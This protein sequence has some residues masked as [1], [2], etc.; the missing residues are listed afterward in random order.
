MK[1][2]RFFHDK[3]QKHNISTFL[4]IYLKVLDRNIQTRKF[5]FCFKFMT[6]IFRIQFEVTFQ[7][8]DHV[9]FRLQF[10]VGFQIYDR[11][12]NTSITICD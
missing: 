5:I 12:C 8:Y 3:Q 4:L 10:N 2:I 9:I 1:Q 6:V 7:F 11:H